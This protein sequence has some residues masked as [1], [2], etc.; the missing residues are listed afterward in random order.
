MKKLILATVVAAAIAGGIGYSNYSIKQSAKLELDKQ[1]AVLSKGSGVQIAYNNLTANILEG[2][3]VLDKI[4]IA[5]PDG[6]PFAD[7]NSIKVI[8][9]H[10]EKIAEYA[11]FN[12]DNLVFSPE[13]IKQVP[14]GI[15]DELIHSNFDVLSTMK[16]DDGLDHAVIKNAL[17]SEGVAAI[18]LDFSLKNVKELFE[19]SIEMN[20]SQQELA[21]TGGELSLEAD[22]QQ[23]TQ[24]ME[25]MMALKPESLTFEIANLGK[26]EQALSELASA[27]NMNLA[28][29]QQK[30]KHQ[31]AYLSV[32]EELKHGIDTFIDELGIMNISLALPENTTVADLQKP[33]ILKKLKTPDGI[34]TFLNLQVATQGAKSL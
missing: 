9:Y 2:S 4:Q 12:L 31:L 24:L 25:V 17:T 10:P 20:K 28:Q 21:E 5:G 8:G 23:Q 26:L 3:I 29:L 6:T 18:K 27:Q 32:P 15:A 1:L 22:L 19:L 30:V 11:E 33:E 34:A 16:Y 7:V 14:A 13:F